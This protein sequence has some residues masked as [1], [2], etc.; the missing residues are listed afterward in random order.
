MTNFLNYKILSVDDGHRSYGTFSW[1]WVIFVVADATI[2]KLYHQGLCHVCD[3]NWTLPYS[4]RSHRRCLLTIFK[5]F[6]GQH[7]EHEHIHINF[8]LATRYA[9]DFRQYCFPRSFNVLVHNFHVPVILWQQLIV[10]F[11]FLILCCV[12][13]NCI[14]SIQ[15]LVLHLNKYLHILRSGWSL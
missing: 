10:I 9:Q 7:N 5:W 13:C 4:Q 6:C 15:L 8:H 11:A 12:L 1:L 14:V 2:A 3:M